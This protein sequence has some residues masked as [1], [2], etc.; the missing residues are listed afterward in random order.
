MA[1][2]PPLPEGAPLPPDPDPDPDDEEDTWPG[3]IEDIPN[4]FQTPEPLRYDDGKPLRPNE[5]GLMAARKTTG[6]RAR[7]SRSCKSESGGA[8]TCKPSWEA[9]VYLKRERRKVRRTFA[10]QAAA[11]AWRADAEG[12][13]NRGK[14][15]GPT[16]LTVR[17][18]AEEFMAEALDDAVF[19]RGG[20][21][22][23]PGTLRTSTPRSWGTCCPRSATSRCPRSR[24][25][26][27][28]RSSRRCASGAS[29]PAA[30]TTRST[31]CA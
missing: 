18:A 23:K 5:R 29:P 19:A 28:K 1:F 10:T 27:W 14:L 21:P 20:R 11:K 16:A 22:Y 17:Q 2:V 30:S 15:R 4:E 24:A 7:H 26:T 8:C 25:M 9:A 13:K 6:I 3:G 31:R 12:A